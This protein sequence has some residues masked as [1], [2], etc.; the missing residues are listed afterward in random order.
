MQTTRREIALL[1]L[2]VVA[3]GGAGFWL[4]GRDDVPAFQLKIIEVKVRPLP[5]RGGLEKRVGVVVSVG[6]DGQQP[7]WWRQG[8]GAAWIQ[9]QRFV[10][11]TGQ[12][13]PI[14][15][16]GSG[17]GFPFDTA[18]KTRSLE[19]TCAVPAGYDVSKPGYLKG[20]VVCA[21]Q[22]VPLKPLGVARFSV[23]VQLR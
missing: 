21:D 14:G 2:P 19:F 10:G 3:L 7:S 1:L 18:R 17:G 16:F 9:N 12:E 6:C 23:P 13:F 4:R 8:V 20:T 5:Q 15:S 11:K 22:L